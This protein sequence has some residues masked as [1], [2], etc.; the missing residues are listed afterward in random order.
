MHDLVE[1]AIAVGTALG[2]GGGAFAAAYAGAK[3]LKERADSKTS[4]HVNLIPVIVERIRR[5]EEDTKELKE[6][7]GRTT[8]PDLS[9]Y[10]ERLS[11]LEDDVR[12][13]AQATTE[14][15][16]TVMERIGRVRGEIRALRED[17]HDR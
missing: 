1:A 10:R 5:L 8:F 14:R 15:L 7:A 3:K 9:D 12:E 13:N 4:G 6:R 11:R 17:D 2:A 16:D